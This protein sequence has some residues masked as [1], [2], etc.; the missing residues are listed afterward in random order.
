LNAV[1]APGFRFTADHP[2]PGI[3]EAFNR[4]IAL[5]AALPCDVMLAPHP[6]SFDLAAKVAK[7]REQPAV[8]PFID[9]Q[10]CKMYAS[11]AKRK[12]KQR[13]AAEREP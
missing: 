5:V 9:P 12:L 2:K 4:S 6:E 3:V 11:N 13:I 7:R 1:S 8:N 10:A